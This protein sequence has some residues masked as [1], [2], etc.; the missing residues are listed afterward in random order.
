MR[1]ALLAL[2]ALA[3]LAPGCGSPDVDNI[4]MLTGNADNGAMVYSSNCA[5]CHGDMGQGGQGIALKTEAAEESDE[6]IVETV[7]EGIETMPAFRD[8]LSDQQ[9]ADVLA[10]IRRDFG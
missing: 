9:I 6:E 5:V 2:A 8:T 1:I 10:F 4:L 7:L 3:T